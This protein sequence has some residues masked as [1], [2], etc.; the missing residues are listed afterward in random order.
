M[1]NILKYGVVLALVCVLA[2]EGATL[3]PAAINA[4]T[5]DNMP[6]ESRTTVGG[7]CLNLSSQDGL[8]GVATKLVPYQQSYQDDT[9]AEVR[10]YIED[11]EKNEEL[12]LQRAKDKAAARQAFFE[13]QAELAR[14]AEE[15]IKQKQESMQ[16]QTGPSL[17]DPSTIQ[18]AFNTPGTYVVEPG[19]ALDNPSSITH[20]QQGGTSLP[21]FS[22]S[23]G[24]DVG[25]VGAAGDLDTGSNFVPSAEGSSLNDT[26]RPDEN[27]LDADVQETYVPE[28]DSTPS[29]YCGEF[30]VQMVCTCSN[31]FNP[32]L[33]PQSR[34]SDSFILADPAYLAPG[35]Q[36]QLTSSE[37]GTYPVHDADGVV[38]GRNVILFHGSHGLGPDSNVLYAK[39]YNVS[40]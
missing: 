2:Y 27:H 37:F 31:C 35:I 12:R 4:P 22:T 38:T 15:L 20:V 10:K 3:A 18:D 26:N 33:W 16:G 23:I 14:Q 29:N 13:Q 25:N 36:V 5:F 34:L 28:S 40:A 19:A 17:N 24:G 21:T 30:V 1:K 11:S 32:T 9:T 8:S 39:I 7:T 6:T